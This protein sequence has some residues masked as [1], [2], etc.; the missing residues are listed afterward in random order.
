MAWGCL[1]AA[2]GRGRLAVMCFL[3]L[4]LLCCWLAVLRWLLL[5]L[6]WWLA[7]VLRVLRVLQGRLAGPAGLPRGSPYCRPGGSLIYPPVSRW[8][9]GVAFVSSGLM[10]C[11]M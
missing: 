7:G 8:I 2:W 4:Q 6:C 1:G 3:L 11:N 5:W 9:K 10:S